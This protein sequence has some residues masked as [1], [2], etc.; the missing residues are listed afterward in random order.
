[1]RIRPPSPALVISCLALLLAL[2]GTSFA[3][4]NATGNAVNIVDPVT[5]ANKAKVD[6]TGKLQVNV[7]G[8]AGARPVAPSTPWSATASINP[9]TPAL[10]IGPR[11]SPINLTSLSASLFFQAAATDIASVE[12]HP[13]YVPGFATTCVNATPEPTLWVISRLTASAPF[14]VSFPTPLQYVPPVGTKGCLFAVAL[15]DSVRF[16]AS[17]FVS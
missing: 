17:G 11:S 2:G 14:A 10:L 15:G 6:A 9:G 7:N 1:M 8:T 3:A 16:N 12:L 13:F 4:I 5:A